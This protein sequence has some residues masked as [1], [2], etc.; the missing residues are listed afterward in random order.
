MPYIK[1]TV[2]KKIDSDVKAELKKEYGKLI[3]IFPGKTESWL[4]LSFFDDVDM[5][6]KG[7]SDKEYAFVEVSIFG[8]ASDS[9][10]DRFTASLCELLNKKL[11]ISKDCIYVKYEESTRWG[12]NGNNF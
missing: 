5:A 8:G 7:S 12:W 9:S 2:S 11:G 1:T 3:E 10:F 4:M 6:F